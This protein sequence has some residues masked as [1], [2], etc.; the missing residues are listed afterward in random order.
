MIKWLLRLAGI[1]FKRHSGLVDALL[2]LEGDNP[3]YMFEK[4]IRKAFMNRLKRNN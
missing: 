3:L 2:W 4:A 1:E